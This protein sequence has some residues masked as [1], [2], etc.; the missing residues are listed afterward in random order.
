MSWFYL[1]GSALMVAF[2]LLWNYKLE[3]S[4]VKEKDKESNKFGIGQFIFF[5][6]FSWGAIIGAV[7]IL[8]VLGVYYLFTET[9]AAKK[10]DDLVKF[11]QR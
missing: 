8:I 11:K 2:M 10:L 3:H 9:S 6:L 1:S 4:N 7:I 5:A